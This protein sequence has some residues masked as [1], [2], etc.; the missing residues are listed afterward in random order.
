MIDDGATHNFLNYGLVKKL[1]LTQSP[2]DHKY[3]VSLANGNDKHVWDTVIKSV[4][5]TIQGDAMRLDFQVMHITRA[6]GF[7]GGNGYII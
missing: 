7:W 1:K 4:P 3:M 2:S 5:L 6:D